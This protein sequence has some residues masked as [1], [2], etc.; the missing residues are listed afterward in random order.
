MILSYPQISIRPCMLLCLCGLFLYGLTESQTTAG[1]L[2]DTNPAPLLNEIMASNTSTIK[3]KDG[4]YPD[5]IEIYNPSN[6]KIDLTG[7]GL[8]DDPDDLFK[9]VFPKSSLPPSGFKLVFASGKNY[10][11]E[12]PHFHTNFKIKSEGE[13]LLLSDPSGAIV[14]RVSTVAIASDYSWGRQPDGAA[15]WFFFD[16]PTP[17][18][19]N[20]TAGYTAFSPSVEFS[21]AGGFY[22][23]GLTLEITSPALAAEIRYTLDC[24]EP[25]QNSTLYSGP[26]LIQKTTVVRARSFTAGLLPGKVTT[27]TYFINEASTLPVASLSTKRENLFDS[28]TGIYENF[29]DD[30]ERPIHF[31]LFEKDGRQGVSVDGGIKI[32]GGLTRRRPQKTFRIYFRPQY[33]YS[34]INY[35]VFPDLPIYEFTTLFLRNS[36][37]DWDQTHFRDGFLQTLV[38][39]L[40]IDTQAYRPAVIFLNGEYWGILNIRERLTEDYLAEHYGVDPDNVDLLE[41]A[42]PNTYV[43]VIEGDLQQFDAVYDYIQKNDLSVDEH[44]QYVQNRIDLNNFIDYVI[45]EIY[46]NNGDWPTNNVKFWR[47]RTE[48]GKFR[49]ML[50]DLDWSY[51]YQQL[52]VGS[53]PENDYRANSLVKDLGT[54]KLQVALMLRQLLKNNRFKT[55]FINRCAGYLNTVFRPQHV[56]AVLEKVK[57]ALEP[58]MPRHYKKFKSQPISYWYDCI[59]IVEEFAQNRPYYLRGHFKN[60]FGLK[61]TVGVS[62]DVSPASAGDIIIDHEKISAFPWLGV[63]FTDMPI[64]F[65]ALPHIGYRFSG[66]T[67]DVASDSIAITRTLGGGISLTA[68]FEKDDNAAQAIVFNEINYNSSKEFDPEDWL[69][70]YNGITDPVN[71]SGW[72]IKDEDDTSGFAF[73]PNT[74]I[75]PAD[76]LVVCRDEEKFHSLFPDVTNHIGDLGFGL[77]NGGELIRLYNAQNVLVDSLAYS[78]SPPWPVEPDGNGPTLMLRDS[79]LDNSL[80]QNWMASQ[81]YGTPGVA[82][83]FFI[84]SVETTQPPQGF[85]LDQNHPNP[86]NSATTIS[87]N[88][89]Y[90]GHVSLKVYNSMGRLVTTLIYGFQNSGRHVFTWNAK[91]DNNIRLAS[92]VYFARLLSGS[93]EKTIA[94]LFIQ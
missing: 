75:M 68:Q 60:Y 70:L 44:Y 89:R 16:A 30:W 20:V 17:E 93:D 56:L 57:T 77:N 61:D 21:Q 15:D 74:I 82:N 28:A 9:W 94:M 43:S 48:T 46:F 12:E 39:G 25:E 36:G 6:V 27:N 32:G 18:T 19:S 8:S 63:Y 66:W 34:H 73:P 87:Y 33:G 1:E 92:G 49:F 67:G 11:T 81:K 72:V 41:I 23:N 45:S 54:S 51:G 2:T 14:D 38:K 37:N 26:I 13:S 47:P 91:D 31:E 88:L 62:L 4:D 42:Y 5:W 59:R 50:F 79:Y 76:Y 71:I 3:D 40:D 86:F 80:P 7:F 65:T 64:T 78:D 58:E 53:G 35:Q 55:D 84:S 52:R 83:T 85:S 24:S 90:G 69:E 22:R 29:W 10:L